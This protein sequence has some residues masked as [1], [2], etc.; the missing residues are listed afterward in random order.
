MGDEVCAVAGFPLSYLNELNQK[1]KKKKKK[2]T[3]P[4]TGAYKDSSVVI[5]SLPWRTIVFTC[6][7]WRAGMG[8]VSELW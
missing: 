4:R 5:Q 3:K 1:K 7:G 8:S 2:P 6:H